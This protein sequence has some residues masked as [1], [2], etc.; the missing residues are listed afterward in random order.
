MKT[1]RFMTIA[2]AVM[3]VRTILVF[4]VCLHS[5]MTHGLFMS[6]MDWAINTIPVLILAYNIHTLTDKDRQWE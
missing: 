3:M 4:L 1:N 2:C 5:K 6:Q